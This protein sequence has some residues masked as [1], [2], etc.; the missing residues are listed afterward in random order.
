[1]VFIRNKITNQIDVIQ[2]SGENLEYLHKF[3]DKN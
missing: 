2:V 1:M 3:Q